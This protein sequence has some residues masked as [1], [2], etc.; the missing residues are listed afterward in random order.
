MVTNEGVGTDIRWESGREPAP[1]PLLSHTLATSP[2]SNVDFNPSMTF[3]SNVRGLT[4]ALGWS[5]TARTR[6]TGWRLATVGALGREETGVAKRIMNSLSV[7]H[8]RAPRTFK[9]FNL[10]RT[11]SD[12]SVT[13]F[14]HLFQLLS[15]VIPICK[16]Q[17]SGVVNLEL[18]EPHSRLKTSKTTAGGRQK[19]SILSCHRQISSLTWIYLD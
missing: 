13:F 17:A 10:S 9:S 5:K 11:L 7:T 4:T 15:R 3:S 14:Q 6:R 16:I 2:A 1:S 18:T 8:T 19:I 12:S